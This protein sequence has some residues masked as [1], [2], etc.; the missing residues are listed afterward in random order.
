MHT[1]MGSKRQNKTPWDRK[2]IGI[3]GKVKPPDEKQ[4]YN[5]LFH[6]TLS[7]SPTRLFLAARIF[8]FIPTSPT[9]HGKL[10]GKKTK[11]KEACLT[12]IKM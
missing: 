1:D 6:H 5:H 2:K 3:H 8:L 11:T 7:N 12:T 9:R 4:V 10:W